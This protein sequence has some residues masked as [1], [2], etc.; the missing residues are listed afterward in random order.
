MTPK[1]SV[2]SLRPNYKMFL[3]PLS[4]GR[5]APTPLKLTYRS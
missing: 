2:F 1:L 4:D 3:I 5:I